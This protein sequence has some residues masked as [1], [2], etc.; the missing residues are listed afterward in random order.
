MY[1]APDTFA[2]TLIVATASG[3]ADT[4]IKYVIINDDYALY[5]PNAFSPNGD[6]TNDIF[7]PVGD[8]IQDYKM[9][10]FDR[11]GD[12]IFYTED[13]T[14][15]WN[16]TYQAKGTNIVQQDTY[17]W[18]IDLVNVLNT[19]KHLTGTVTLLK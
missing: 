2:V 4:V 7:L 9:Y 1:N 11:W 3:C 13:I 12:L 10:I 16:G 15:G 18:K 8:G 14:K 5:V 17:V 6:N 19:P